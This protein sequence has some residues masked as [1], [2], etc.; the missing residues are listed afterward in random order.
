VHELL[1]VIYKVWLSQCEVNA[2]LF[3]AEA[4]PAAPRRANRGIP[5]RDRWDWQF[6]LQEFEKVNS[7]LAVTRAG[8]VTFDIFADEDNTMVPGAFWSFANS[9]WP[10]L[11]V[12]QHFWANCPYEQF[13]ILGM[14]LKML[15]DF[16][17]APEETSFTVN[18]PVWE[19]SC[20]GWLV[21]SFFV[22]LRDFPSGTTL[23]TTPGKHC[24]A[25]EQLMKLVMG[26]FGSMQ[27]C[28]PQ[29]WFI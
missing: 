13:L 20:F 1:S 7:Q 12:R 21:N 26:E 6:A 3:H 10:H 18:V 22:K 23:Y 28:G 24:Y 19:G 9:C 15:L 5:H 11:W 8:V 17:R 4:E 14:L 25:R 29:L 2:H 16:V 27:L